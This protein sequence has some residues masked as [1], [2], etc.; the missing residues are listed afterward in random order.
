MVGIGAMELIFMGL[1]FLIVASAA[2]GVIY[3]GVRLA[4]RHERKNS[5]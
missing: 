5:N 3:V 1:V 4:L 2:I